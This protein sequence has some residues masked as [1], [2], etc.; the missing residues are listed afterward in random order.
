MDEFGRVESGFIEKLASL[1]LARVV[2]NGSSSIE[3]LL[4]PSARRQ[5]AVKGLWRWPC[6]CGYYGA[7]PSRC[8]VAILSLL[9]ELWVIESP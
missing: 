5:G 7:P 4:G 6:G 8:L 9:S 3:L 2:E 1:G